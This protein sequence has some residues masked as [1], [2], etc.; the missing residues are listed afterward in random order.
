MQGRPTLLH[1]WC[2][3]PSTLTG[4]RHQHAA[5][6]TSPRDKPG[7]TSQ[8][9]GHSVGK[10]TPGGEPHGP[11]SPVQPHSGLPAPRAPGLEE[12]AADLSQAALLTTT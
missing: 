8:A 11:D 2:Q 12:P 3:L 10:Q 9:D 5:G 6:T 4:Q 1:S 7:C